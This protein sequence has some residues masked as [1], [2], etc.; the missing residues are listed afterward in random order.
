[1]DEAVKFNINDYVWVRLTDAGKIACRRQHDE[2]RRQYPMIGKY[3]PPETDA[4]GYSRWQLWQLMQTFGP[5][6]S[7]GSPV[8]FDT[9]I[10]IEAKAA[11]DE[12]GEDG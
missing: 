3:V 10:K 1:M 2:L 8:P 5:S 7:H 12:Q 4:Q 6:I 9:E 11:P